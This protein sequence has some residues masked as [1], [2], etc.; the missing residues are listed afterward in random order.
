MNRLPRSCSA[1]VVAVAIASA[2]CGG[3]STGPSNRIPSV[4]GAYSGTVTVVYPELQRSVT[5]PASTTV[6][7]SGSTVN[8]APIVLAGQ[9]GGIS[10][11]I[12]Q[13]TIDSTGAVDGGSGSGTYNEPSC[14]VYSYSFSGGFFGREFRASANYTSRTCYNFNFT[15]TLSR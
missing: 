7:Q 12:G 1:L 8:I 5:C 2:G 4:N 13:T 14:G 6:T 9:C 3:S 11:P 10:I 15:M